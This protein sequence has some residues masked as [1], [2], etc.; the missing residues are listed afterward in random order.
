MSYY[1]PDRWIIVK[2]H[3]E[4]SKTTIYKILGSWYGGYLGADEWRLSSGITSIKDNGSHYLIGNHSGSEYTCFKNSEGASA[5][6]HG[7]L[8][9]LISKADKSGEVSI[10][11]IDISEVKL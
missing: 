8:S 2:V 1:T 11:R 10:S 4:E 6:S 7:V 9:E 5:Y 3:H